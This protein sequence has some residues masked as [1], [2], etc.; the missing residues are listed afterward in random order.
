MQAV[1]SADGAPA[2]ELVEPQGPFQ[3]LV[4]PIRRAGLFEATVDFS[5]LSEVDAIVICVPTPLT[6]HREPDLSFIE[7]TAKTIG[8]L[9]SGQ[10]VVLESTSYPG[11]T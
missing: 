5:R 4:S 6:K 11:T 1:Q 9:R 3:D 8:A 7:R 10:L 2:L